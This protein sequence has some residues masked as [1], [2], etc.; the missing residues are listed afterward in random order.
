MTCNR[1]APGWERTWQ[2]WKGKGVQFVGV[3]LLDSKEAC[4][5][6]IRRHDLTFANGYDGD[7]RVAKLYGFTYQPFWAVIG[8]DGALVKA[9]YGP[10]SEAELVSMLRTITR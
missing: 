4:A 2:A 6:F 8:K 9:G 3:G 10:A 5:G 7:G 1:D